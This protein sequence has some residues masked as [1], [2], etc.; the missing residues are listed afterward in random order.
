MS[1]TETSTQ[2]VA[3]TLPRYLT[4]G[5]TEHDPPPQK[6]YPIPAFPPPP[7]IEPPPEPPEINPQITAPAPDPEQMTFS[8]EL[9]E[10]ARYRT[11]DVHPPPVPE[12]PRWPGFHSEDEPA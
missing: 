1:E 11:P 10:G 4:E 2:T 3:E 12:H 7:V 8:F 9:S 6:P 5:R